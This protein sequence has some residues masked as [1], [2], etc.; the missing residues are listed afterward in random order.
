[1]A[2]PNEP[3]QKQECLHMRATLVC[4][5]W[6][7]FWWVSFWVFWVL[8]FVYNNII[9]TELRVLGQRYL[10]HALPDQKLIPGPARLLFDN[11]VKP[12]TSEVD[13]IVAIPPV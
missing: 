10:S 7:L 11:A 8:V 13:S 3:Q 4:F 12:R 1:M 2:V 9:T 6:P 5:E